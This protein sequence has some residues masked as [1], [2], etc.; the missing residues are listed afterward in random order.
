[1]SK[2]VADGPVTIM[3]TDVEG[4][5][6]LHARRG[7]AEARAILVACQNLM[8]EQVKAA[9]GRAVKSTGDG[10]MVTFSS[11][12]KALSGALA[13]QDALQRCG[14]GHPHEPL[15]VRIGI[16]TG[17]ACAEDGEMYGAAI[18]AAARIASRAKGGEV[19][20]SDVVR[21]LC[22]P[23]ADLEF[24]DQGS[25][26]LRGFPERWRLHRVD[27]S[28]AR[29]GSV[30]RGERTPFIGRDPERAILRDLMARTLSGR[31][32]LAMIGGE[33]GVGKTRLVEQIAAEAQ[34]RFRV[35]VGNCD[36]REGDLPY[37]PWLEIL[38]AAIGAAPHGEL[39]RELGDEAPELA[40]LLPRLRRL[41]PDIPPA[42][43]LPPD[44]QRRHTFDSVGEYLTRVARRKPLLIVLED[45]H[46][47]DEGTVRL[48]KRLANRACTAPVMIVCT[49]RDSPADVSPT[50]ALVLSELVRCRQATLLNLVPHT[51]SEVAAMLQALSGSSTPT[52][53][54]LHIF[55]HTE[56]NAFFVEEVFLHLVERGSLIN[57][58]GR[59][60][61][62]LGSEREDVPGNV[63]LVTGQRLARLSERTR[64]LLTVAA[65]IGRQFSIE[66]LLS[67]D[68]TDGDELLDA[69]DE[70]ELARVVRSQA[71]A[72]H[73]DYVFAH[74]LIRQTLLGSISP[75]RRARHHLAVAGA[76]EMVHAG[77]LDRHVPDIA[78]HLLAAGS[79]ADPARTARYLTMAGDGAQATA[80]FEEALRDYEAALS[81]LPPEDRRS[82]AHLLV[83]LGYAQRALRRW[84]EQIAT[85][86]EA[87]LALE[88]LGDREALPRLGYWFA[89][90]LSLASRYD[91]MVRVLERGLRAIGETPC[92]DR[93]GLM[94]M[95]GFG[96][97]ST[98]RFGESRTHIDEAMRF[99]EPL[100]DVNLLS[101]V[102][103]AEVNYH[104]TS[105]HLPEAAEAAR[106]AARTSREAGHPLQ[107]TQVL[108]LAATACA[109]LGRF[110][111]ANALREE[112]E[113]LAANLGDWAVRILAQRNRFLCSA[114]QVGDLDLL[115]EL[116]TLGA[117]GDSR[118]DAV[119]VQRALVH[120]WRGEWAFA[121]DQIE[122]A[123]R[124]ARPGWWYG[125]HQGFLVILR[126]YSGDHAQACALL[127]GERD[128]LP[129]PGSLNTYGAWHLAILAAEGMGATGDAARARVL[130]PLVVEAL[131]TGTVTR[132]YDGRLVQTSAAIAAATAGLP[133]Q[134]EAHF[135]IAMQQADQL[136]HVIE[137]PHVRHFYA[138][139]LTERGGAGDHDRAH[140]LVDQAIADFRRIGMPRHEAM[141][142]DLRARLG[143]RDGGGVPPSADLVGRAQRRRPVTEGRQA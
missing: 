47:S 131:A 9:G 103:P 127:D 63:R 58:N 15:R 65:V 122:A 35:L 104:M 100:G 105:M 43:E 6:A 76:L 59:L 86:D 7:D 20:V 74:E 80:A 60:T 50:L 113:S 31:G 90:Q 102:L 91:D 142:R 66:L 125:T 42:M 141:S 119:G 13:L 124:R 87:L 21:Q 1:M 17:L 24:T 77:D 29:R 120:F 69:L 108:G 57:D 111:E 78:H 70:A 5:T 11:P 117:A 116:S 128:T 110:A 45:L 88:E 136:P 16:H 71:S 46:W 132:A 85:W 33:P 137:R 25:V 49:Y 107:M 2:R 3:F 14:Y 4:S 38:E 98:G 72:R 99:A 62:R 10:L 51:Q 93:A 26:K 79:A 67:I 84:K 135:E 97:C 12:R 82:R 92:P 112:F 101:E 40:L 36:E 95:L 68:G 133:E 22:G 140:R 28:T 55:S 115:D 130:Y 19:L 139:F 64:R 56:G 129:T 61:A 34:R 121:R 23:A 73:T 30:A 41:L 54:A 118:P 53:V 89:Y 48:L 143:T 134:A 138:H 94:A 109:G 96:L 8:R 18:N 114:A 52:E 44:E 32:G 39:S 106:R 83:K 37:R 123:V 75:A 126:A 27:R 81:V